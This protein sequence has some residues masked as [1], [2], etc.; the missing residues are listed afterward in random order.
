MKIAVIGARGAVGRTCVEELYKSGHTP[1]ELSRTDTIDS[2]TEGVIVAAQVEQLNFSGAIV[3]CTG[4]L[5]NTQLALPSVL[6]A[7]DSP[8]R[9]PNCMA[10]LIAQAIA[11]L[12]EQ[13]TIISIVATCMQSA[14][15]AGWRGAQALET[16]NTNEL[17]GGHL[18]G[19]VLPHER[20]VQEETM[21]A[22][23][24]KIIFGCTVIATSFRVP[25]ITGHVASLHIT[26]QTD[27]QKN[28][29]QEH[30]TIDPRSMQGERFVSLGRVR[31]QKNTADLVVCGD[32]LLCGTAI[33]A[34]QL[35][36]GL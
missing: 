30:G 14:S 27:I 15:G 5:P 36:L 1:S 6:K 31:I 3:D 10:S 11:P 22:N 4:L 19:N 20:A 23:D 35:I 16:N 33:P 21:I 12:H 29:L 18:V 32:Q 25:V 9:I 24:L 13:C 28:T 26:T 8:L 34:V 7:T 17:F 2:D